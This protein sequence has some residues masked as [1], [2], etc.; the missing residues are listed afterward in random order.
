MMAFLKRA[1]SA[2]KKDEKSTDEP[3]EKVSTTETSSKRRRVDVDAPSEVTTSE[4]LETE[5]TTEE[6]KETVLKIDK[7]VIKKKGSTASSSTCSD[8]SRF[9]SMLK[10]Y[11]VTNRNM[12]SCLIESD[13]PAIC[14]KTDCWMGIDEAGRG[15]VC[16]PMNYGIAYGPIN[17]EA[18]LK[19]MGFADSKQLSEDQRDNLWE[20][21]KKNDDFLGWIISILSPQD[22]SMSMLGKTNYNLNAMSHDT[23]IHL[24]RRVLA[25]GVQLTEVYVDTVGKEEWYQAKLEGLFPNLK[26]TVTSKADVKFPIVSAASICAKVSRDAILNQWKYTENLSALSRVFGS[27]YP[28][29]PNCKKWL[30][31]A[32]DPIF[33][34]PGVARFSWAT[35]KKILDEKCAKVE[36]EDD[37]SDS[38]TPSVMT[39]FAKKSEGVDKKKRHRFFQ[40]ASLKIVTEF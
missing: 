4:V 35:V 38:E 30:I 36:W 15:P 20:V 34:F 13:V 28:G 1:P 29:D 22:I 40:N 25:L 5:M 11:A 7:A 26:I 27:G 14:K 39:F 18:K 24:I 19:A 8:G 33:G 23:A 21:I 2:D 12:N 31:E 17:G 3:S 16:G 37:D 10:N 9:D 32:T 6:I